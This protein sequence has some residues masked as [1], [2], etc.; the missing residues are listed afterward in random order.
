MAVLV[1]GVVLIAVAYLLV[2]TLFETVLARDLQG[3]FGLDSVPEVELR[4][5]PGEMLAGDFEG[6]RVVL[7]GYDLGGV[8]PEEVAIDLSPFDVGVLG[9][10]AAGEISFRQAPVGTLRAT[11]SEAEVGRIAASEVVDFPVQGVEL[12][13]GFALAYTEFY[14][15]G[16]SVPVAVEGGVSAGEN[17]LIFEPSNV[18]AA[19]VPVPNG[20][21]TQ[22][23]GGLGFVY[24]IGGLPPGT[25]I[26]GAEVEQDL[27]VLTGPTELGL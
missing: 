8:R 14:A 5:S 4:G 18:E 6:G 7:P 3:R 10:V 16:Q 2:P 1:V 26:T 15:L 11:L 17:A 27:L 12:E 13:N 24:P 20:L 21:A 19:G 23:L 22:M 25:R 9:S